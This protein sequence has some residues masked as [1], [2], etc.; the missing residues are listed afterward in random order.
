MFKPVRLTLDHGRIGRAERTRFVETENPCFGWAALT[1]Y[2][3]TKQAACRVRVYGKNPWDSGWVEKQEQSMVYA[4][5]PLPRGEAVRFDITLRDDQDHVSETIEERFYLAQ[6]DWRAPWIGIADD[7]PGETVYLRRE[8]KTEKKLQAACIY[9]IGIGYHKLF[10][11]GRAL[12]DYVLEPA[13]TDYSKTCQYVMLPGLENMMNQGKHCFGAMTGDGWR[14]PGLAFKRE[15]FFTG[16]PCFSAMIYLKYHDGEENWIVTDT[17]WQAGRGAHVRNNLFSGEVYDARQTQHGWCMPDFKGFEHAV[18]CEAPGGTMRPMLIPPIEVHR[19]YRPV[20]GWQ[21][22]NGSYMIDFGQNLAGVIRIKFHKRLKPGQTITV[23]HAEELDEDGTLYRA[24]LRQAE[25]ADTY[26]A[27][28]DDNDLAVWQPMF[29]YHGFRYIC[30]TGLD[31]IPEHCHIE[32]VELH[33]AIELQS[34]FRC[35]NALINKI[36]DICVQTE[37]HN[38][39]GILTDCPQ[40]D[41]RQGWMNDATVRFE[42]APYNFDIGRIFPKIIRDIIDTQ[43]EAGSISCTAPFVFG[44]NPADPVCSSFLVAG[45]ESVLHTGNLA[46]I[47]EAYKGFRAWT[48]Y[49]LSRTSNLI[50]DY[51]Y[52]GDWAGPQYACNKDGSPRS[53]VTPGEFMSTGYLYYNCKTLTRF[54][55]W[56]DETGEADKWTEQAEAVCRAMTAKWYNPEKAIMATGSQACQAFSLWLGIIPEKD[57]QRAAKLLRDELVRSGYSFTTG[58]LCTRYLADV[59]TEYG[60][61]DDAWALVTR[62]TYPSWGYMIQQEATTVWERFELKKDPGMNS[63]S[64]PMYGAIDEWLYRYIAGIRPAEPG[65]NVIDIRPFFPERLLSAQATVDTIKGDVSVRWTKRF[66]AINLFVNIPFGTIANIYFDSICHQVK[67]GFHVFQ[68]PLDN[69]V[70]GSFR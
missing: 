20:T 21:L 44:K 67:S 11:D 62:E 22:D 48:S 7:K 6:T 29:T 42:A 65:W 13:H 51:S 35:G 41:E 23:H 63:H 45:M 54:A 60:Y 32:A 27:S 9:A 47:A 33:S 10:L 8:F 2:K 52:Y 53:G 26:I 64:H 61:V 58:N 70:E 28:G 36:H 5:P 50:V 59:L 46:I 16:K 4:G 12:D 40:R 3:C 39:H 1:K 49:L 57:R 17:T 24:P 30:I 55:R 38:S 56:L 68:K 19:S 66:G 34:N 18:S 31:Y 43:Q 15:P 69:E 37:R 25:A 14:R